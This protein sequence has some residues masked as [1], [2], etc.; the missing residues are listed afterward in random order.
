MSIETYRNVVKFICDHCEHG[1]EYDVDNII[2]R[3]IY[4][5]YP[6]E[7]HC[8]KK[9]EKWLN[10]KDCFISFGDSIDRPGYKRIFIPI[11]SYRFY[12][13]Y[14]NYPN[15]ILFIHIICKHV[16]S[17]HFYFDYRAIIFHTVHY[18]FDRD[19]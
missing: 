15:Y 12:Y 9:M 19:Q 6:P 1:L 10:I 5:I 11:F 7:L 17:N 18:I 16:V 8:T 13:F 2:I 3:K 14:E 4:A